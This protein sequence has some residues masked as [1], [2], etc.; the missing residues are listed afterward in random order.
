ML[1]EKATHG[2]NMP[3]G[4]FTA[5]VQALSSICNAVLHFKSYFQP[6]PPPTTCRLS[7]SPVT[8]T[9]QSCL[10]NEVSIKAKKI[11]LREIQDCEN[12]HI[13]YVQSGVPQLHG[14]DVPVFKAFQTSHT[15]FYISVHMHPL[16]SALFMCNVVNEQESSNKHK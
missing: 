10:Y 13:M 4:Q 11:W 5:F 15:A 7:S 6:H 9:D 3:S 2:P 1:Q 16:K 8:N 12:K 14:K